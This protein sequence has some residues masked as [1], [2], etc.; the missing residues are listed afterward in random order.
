MDRI[1]GKHWHHISATELLEILDSNQEHG[2]DELEAQR[3][4]KELGPNTLPAAQGASAISRFLAQ[5]HQPLVYILVIASLITLVL[6]EYV[7]SAVIFL[8]VFVNAVVGFVQENKALSALAALSKGMKTLA[9][10]IRAGS[11]TQISSEDLVPGDIV[12]LQ[13]GD[14]VPADLRLLSVKDLQIDEST[15]TGESVAVEKTDA[16]LAKELLLPERRNMAYS[17]CLVSYGQGLGVVVATATKTEVGR[18]S[19]LITSAD[20]LATPLTRK[21]NRFTHWLL[22]AIL[23]LGVLT[24]FLGVY[25]GESAFEMFMATVALIVGAIPEG[26]PAA[27]TIV[28]AIGV[29]RMAKRRAIIRK[30]PAVET[31]GSTTI[32]CSDKTGTLTEN[33]MTV[34]DIYAGAELFSVSGTGYKP[35]G[36]I[37]P[38]NANLAL[39]ECLLAGLLCNEAV[40]KKEEERWLIQGDPTEGALLVSAAKANISLEEM[41]NKFPRLDSVPFESQHQYMATLH[42]APSSSKRFAFVKG[43]SERILPRCRSVL[44]ADGQITEIEHNLLESIFSSL[45]K[46]GLRVLS[47]AK[48]ECSAEKEKLTSDDL[49]DNLVFL[50]FQAMIDPPRPEAISA[51][52]T[53]QR[54]GVK[55]KMITGDHALTAANIAKHLGLQGKPDST[56]ESLAVLSG[57]E[58][59]QLSDQKLIEVVEDVAVFARVTPEQKLRLVRALQAR[60]HIVAMTGDGVNDAPALRQADIGVAMGITGTEVAKEAADMV[61]TDDNFVSIEAAIE[62]GRG[63][64]DNLSKFILWTLPTNIGEG[65]VILVAVILATA[66]PLLPLHILW[67]N[68]NTAMLLGIMLAFEPKEEGIMLRPPLNPKQAIL[69]PA[70]VRRMLLVASLMLIFSF[71]LFSWAKSLGSSVEAARTIA[72]N[73]FVMIE[74]FFLFNCRSLSEPAHKLGF[75]SNPWVIVGVVAM[76]FLQMLFT[77]LPWMNRVFDSAPIQLADWALIVLASLFTYSVVEVDKSIYRKKKPS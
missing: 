30:L 76:L 59:E 38:Q 70:F 32:I 69:K 31:L 75:F 39:K 8:V 49:Q 27:I 6:E 17:S 74:I 46:K 37:T 1:L 55:V 22:Y 58:L 16:I 60:Q 64:Y 56:G 48:L 29:N 67:I 10:V 33:Q 35:E 21:I 71:A 18:I 3:R 66:L 68:M 15:L 36:L 50:G 61:L 14:K 62:E 57:K 44:G 45:A 41:K 72:V 51:V 73:V 9:N 4:L 43:A 19:E 5:F 47:F 40:L 23:A 65:M 20:D 11:K 24:F 13:S 63:V 25:R 34:S 54:A 7:D 53:C 2:L 28:L 42:V 26:L 77:Y 12:F 52:A